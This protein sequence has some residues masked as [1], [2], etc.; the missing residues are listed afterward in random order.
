MQTVLLSSWGDAFVK[1]F[2]NSANIVAV[3]CLL[4]GLVLCCIECFIP[5]FGVFGITGTI[6]CV[7]SLV[8]TLIIG[9]EHAWLQFLY[10]VSLSVAVLAI[11]IFIAIRSARFGALSKSPLVQNDVALPTDFAS[12]EK[13]YAFLVGKTGKTKTILKP[14]GK[15][16]FDGQTYQ[17][18]TEGEYIDKGKEIYVSEVDGSTITVKIK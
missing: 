1:M 10:L 3:V 15:A 13:N 12:N 9:G 4:I 17:V 11:V 6:F 5:G 7:F 18:T 16:E 14:I 2:T 8:F